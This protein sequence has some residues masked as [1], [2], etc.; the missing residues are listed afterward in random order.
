[1]V[2]IVTAAAAVV[3]VVVVGIVIVCDFH[4]IKHELYSD[5]LAYLVA[6][7]LRATS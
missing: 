1:M 5:A 4:R 2:T 6:S 7:G 3:G